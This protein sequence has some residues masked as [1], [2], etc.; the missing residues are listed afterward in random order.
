MK[1]NSQISLS[2]DSEELRTKII[3][4]INT[5]NFA[6]QLL[7]QDTESPVYLDLNNEAIAKL[8]EAHNV[9]ITMEQILAMCDFNI[10]K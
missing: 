8:S 3:A 6:N 2:N 5:R 9:L 7:T 10:P 1:T 4:E